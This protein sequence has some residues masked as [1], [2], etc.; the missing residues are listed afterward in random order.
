M[1]VAMITALLFFTGCGMFTP[2]T[3]ND[4]S[5][6]PPSSAD[7]NP[8]TSPP[9]SE[10]LAMLDKLTSQSLLALKR[11]DSTPEALLEV[12]TQTQEREDLASALLLQRATGKGILPDLAVPTVR[13]GVKGNGLLKMLAGTALEQLFDLSEL[14]RSEI[15]STLGTKLATS[16]PGGTTLTSRE[17]VT[18]DGF[19]SLDGNEKTPEGLPILDLAAEIPAWTI[20]FGRDNLWTNSASPLD[21]HDHGL[22][23]FIVAKS[24]IEW[25]YLFGLGQDSQPVV[26]G[27]LS[28]R[29]D[30]PSILRGIYPKEGSNE[31]VLGRRYSVEYPTGNVVAYADSMLE[32]W[33][34]LSTRQDLFTQARLWRA[35][36][37]AFAR[38][39]ADRR[40]PTA[41]LF[42]DATSDSA[43]LPS[44]AHELPLAFLATLQ[45]SINTESRGFLDMNK[46]VF[47]EY[48]NRSP[49]A[50]EDEASLASLIALTQAFA[51]WIDAITDADKSGISPSLVE[52][53]KGAPT[54]LKKGLQL[55]IQSIF[56]TSMTTFPDQKLTILRH[57]KASDAEY[58]A[59]YAIALHALFQARAVLEKSP[60]LDER[61]E[62]LT[63]G[64]VRTVVLPSVKNQTLDE[65]TW[66]WMRVVARDMKEASAWSQKPWV[67]SFAGLFRF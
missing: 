22:Q 56:A 11:V 63:E 27:G 23:T 43:L 28:L 60:L 45:T 16:T 49:N 17:A 57:P 12:L 4:S 31:L 42:S 66:L 34:P 41:S 67:S 47:R 54:Q 8:T 37:Q 40:G 35:A 48:D 61:L 36:G 62:A 5:R 65:A 52:R 25:G 20:A 1:R 46:R 10:P 18:F 6:T 64:Y 21:T 44:D 51:A 39:R 24:L 53:V 50:P 26:F 32:K 7:A 30:T 19:V 3:V 58:A 29:P 13:A 2:P 33:T 9:S 38:L 59:L 15:R 14:V 55:A